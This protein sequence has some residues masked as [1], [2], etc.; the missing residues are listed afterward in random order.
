MRHT[1]YNESLY[2]ID[3]SAIPAIH[4]FDTSSNKAFG[5]SKRRMLIPSYCNPFT[6]H[7]S[8]EPSNE[9]CTIKSSELQETPRHRFDPADYRAY[10]L[11]SRGYEAT[12]SKESTKYLEE[13]DANKKRQLHQ[14][15]IAARHPDIGRASF[16]SG[17]D[18]GETLLPLISEGPDS[19]V[20]EEFLRVDY[21]LP[22]S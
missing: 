19:F 17:T 9:L 5:P 10:A 21:F 18:L 12:Q 11:S 14:S 15:N 22:R 2:N 20:A 13:F 4:I 7:Q 3:E 1:S 8:S 16:L 6:V